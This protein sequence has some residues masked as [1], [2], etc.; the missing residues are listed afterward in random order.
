V[1]TKHEAELSLEMFLSGEDAGG[2]IVVSVS[3]SFTAGSPAHMGSLSYAG[4]P[5]DPDEIE[6]ESIKLHDNDGNELEC[7]AWLTARI[8]KHADMEV[9][10]EIAM[11]E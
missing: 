5:A 2:E 11:E 7:P 10:R 6:I 1:A 8:E 4:N 9:L 3:F